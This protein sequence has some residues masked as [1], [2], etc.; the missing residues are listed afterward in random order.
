MMSQV[1]QDQRT[2]FFLVSDSL[3][4]HKRACNTRYVR[5]SCLIVLRAV[6]P[7]I[8]ESKWEKASGWCGVMMRNRETC[9]S[10]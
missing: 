2:L 7:D 3:T 9:F 4:V 10:P 6:Y 1:L 8:L 5:S